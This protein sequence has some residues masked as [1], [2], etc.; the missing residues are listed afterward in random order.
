MVSPKFPQLDL[1]LWW[2]LRI[3]FFSY[4]IY[5]FCVFAG[6][7]VDISFMLLILLLYTSWMCFCLANVKQIG[8]KRRMASLNTVSTEKLIAN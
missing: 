8:D 1:Q 2:L 7:L 5:S 6:L 3:S 4:F